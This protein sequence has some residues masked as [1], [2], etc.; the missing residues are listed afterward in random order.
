MFSLEFP[1][2]KKYSWEDSAV[3]WD[4]DE[5]EWLPFLHRKLRVKR[6]TAT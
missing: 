2:R 3:R 1:L 6:H 4:E 5:N